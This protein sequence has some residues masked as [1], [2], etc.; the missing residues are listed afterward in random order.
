VLYD[1]RGRKVVEASS[2][3]SHLRLEALDAQG[4]PLAN[5]V[6][7]YVVTYTGVDGS[8]AITHIKKL[9]LLR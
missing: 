1:L 4:R 6:Y 2:K 8:V 5:G 7:F 3:S 9:V